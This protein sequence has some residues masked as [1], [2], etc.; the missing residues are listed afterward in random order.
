MFSVQRDLKCMFLILKTWICYMISIEACLLLN[1][2]LICDFYLNKK[3]KKT[4]KQKKQKKNKK[5][6]YIYSGNVKIE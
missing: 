3:T 4:K 2:L 1:I 5:Y 6:I